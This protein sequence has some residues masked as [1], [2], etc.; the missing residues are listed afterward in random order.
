M[1]PL[2]LDRETLLRRMGDAAP[3][4]ITDE[5]IDAFE[6]AARKA[7]EEGREVQRAFDAKRKAMAEAAKAGPPQP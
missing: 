6:P 3:E 2:R 7:M 4:W 1:G 5:L